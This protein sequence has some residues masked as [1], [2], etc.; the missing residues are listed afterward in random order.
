MMKKY[1]LFYLYLTLFCDADVEAV[2]GHNTI[3]DP[4]SKQSS[5][6]L[7]NGRKIR[8][9]IK[10]S[11]LKNISSKCNYFIRITSKFSYSEPRILVVFNKYRQKNDVEL[12][13]M[14]WQEYSYEDLTSMMLYRVVKFNNLSSNKHLQS[15]IES[16]PLWEL[17]HKK[18]LKATGGRNLKIEMVMGN[19]I[20]I[21]ETHIPRLNPSPSERIF[22]K[23]IENILKIL[24]IQRNPYTGGDIIDKMITY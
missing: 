16:S 18:T 17:K 8:S 11:S 20:K 23:E 13:S 1:L 6:T 9:D 14:K 21:I 15:C 4:I 24:K 3:G 5:F 10:K 7:I 12:Y 19:K 2:A 22:L